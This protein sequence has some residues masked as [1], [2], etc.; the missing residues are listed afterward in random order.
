MG[1][2]LRIARWY[3][4]LAVGCISLSHIESRP[5]YDSINAVLRAW[6]R[7]MRASLAVI[8]RARH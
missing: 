5:D 8:A 1:K 3:A 6:L 4:L 2:T 7:E